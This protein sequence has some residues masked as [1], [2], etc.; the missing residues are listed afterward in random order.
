[1][2]IV[3]SLHRKRNIRMPIINVL[4]KTFSLFFRVERGESVINIV[5]IKRRFYL[6]IQKRLASKCAYTKMRTLMVK[7]DQC[8]KGKL[9]GWQCFRV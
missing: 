5:T 6:F 1:M 2:C 7:K 4:K 8:V 3:F 9:S